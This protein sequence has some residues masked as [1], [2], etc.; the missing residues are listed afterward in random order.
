MRDLVYHYGCRSP[1]LRRQH[2]RVIVTALNDPSHELGFTS[3]ALELDAKN[4]HTWAYRQWALSHFFA[5]DDAHDAW[6]GELAYVDQLLDEDVRNNS[7][8]NHRWFVVFARATPASVEVVDR[9]VRC[10]SSA[11]PLEHG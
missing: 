5:E 9:E 4:Y 10:D 7:A 11:P 6:Q 3:R 1:L 2:R 8:W